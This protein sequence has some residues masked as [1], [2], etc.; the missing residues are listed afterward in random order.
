MDAKSAVL[1][2]LDTNT[3]LRAVLNQSSASGRLLA[4]CETRRIPM[5]LSKP[6]LAEYAR[7]LS[8][9]EVLKRNPDRARTDIR[10]FLERL[11]YLSRRPAMSS[12]TF[13]FDRDPRDAMFIELAIAGRASHIVT[14]DK[15]L[16]S[17][18]TSRSDA[19]RRF[20]QR[21]PGVKALTANSF[22]NEY[23]D[24]LEPPG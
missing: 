18:P 9:P 1:V 6:V 10:A 5:L 24:M 13:T 21:L 2:V 14:H 3:V 22:L 19:G 16:L 8:S 12:I 20:R 23:S 4:G 15:D 11:R 17:L 7:V